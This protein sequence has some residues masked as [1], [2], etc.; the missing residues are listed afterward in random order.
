MP[1]LEDDAAAA[2]LIVFLRVEK[3]CHPSRRAQMYMYGIIR[4]AFLTVHRVAK[5]KSSSAR[6]SRLRP[7]RALAAAAAEPL[8]RR[9]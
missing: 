4:V 7:P 8:G 3:T 2:S 9:S 6:R 5:Q 1:S